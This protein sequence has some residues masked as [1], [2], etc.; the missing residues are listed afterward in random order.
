MATKGAPMPVK[1]ERL[2]MRMSTEHKRLLEQA[3]AIRGQT[4]SSFALSRL[5]ED[6]EAIVRAH[7]TTALSLRDQHTLLEILGDR[8]EP[9]AAL[10]TAVAAWKRNRRKPRPA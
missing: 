3:A 6:A 7:R 8:P 1:P 2:E 10:R 4:L 5:L 9:S